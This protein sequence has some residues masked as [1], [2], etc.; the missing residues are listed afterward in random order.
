[1][2]RLLHGSEPVQAESCCYCFTRS[3]TPWCCQ[4]PATLLGPQLASLASAAAADSLPLPALLRT[5]GCLGDGHGQV[6]CL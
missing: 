1:M 6:D 3:A 5:H 4:T 2:W